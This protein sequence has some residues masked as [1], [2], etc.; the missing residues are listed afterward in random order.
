MFKIN[1]P[2]K[3]RDKKQNGDQHVKFEWNLIDDYVYVGTNACCQHHFDME[4]INVGIE[5]NISMEL[6]RLDKPEGVQ[7]FLWIPTKDHTA[8]TLENLWSG[9]KFIQSLV[10]QRRKV[11]I[12]CKNGHGRAPTMAAAYYILNG[13]T[14]E[15]AISFVESRRDEAHIE[16]AQKDALRR[17]QE[18]LTK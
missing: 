13:K 14:V 3:I 9:A 1:R 6:E 11:Y 16:P 10:V 18:L 17:F 15:E 8:P 12:H 2:F 5:A 4:L 7:M